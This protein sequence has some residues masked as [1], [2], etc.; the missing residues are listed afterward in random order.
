MQH[1]IHKATTTNDQIQDQCA[2]TEQCSSTELLTKLQSD[3]VESEGQCDV[4]DMRDAAVLFT[5]YCL[6]CCKRLMQA[7]NS[8]QHMQRE[9]ARRAEQDAQTLELWRRFAC[10][11]DRDACCRTV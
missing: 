4:N 11:D 1:L 3:T 5:P 8:A 7:S 9:V 6:I 10:D 2:E